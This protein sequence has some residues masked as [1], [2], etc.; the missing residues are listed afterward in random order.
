M[1][2][3]DWLDRAALA[4]YSVEPRQFIDFREATLPDGQRVNRRLQRQRADLHRPARSREDV[5]AAHY[6]GRPLTWLSQNSPH[7]P[8][9]GLPWLQQ[10]NGGLVVIAA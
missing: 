1:T 9:F 3:H 10:F 5:W 8:D 4:R 6:N 2:T 7:L